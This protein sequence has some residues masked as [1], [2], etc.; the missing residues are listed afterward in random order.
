MQRSQAAVELIVILAVALV[1]LLSILAIN[2]S[3]MTSSQ[4]QIEET[5]ARTALGDIVNAAEL[6]YQGGVGSKTRVFVTLPDNIDSTSVSG[7]SVEISLYTAGGLNKIHRTTDFFV[8]GDIPAEEGNHWIDVEARQNDVLIGVETAAVCG[9]DAAEG[10]EIC[11]GTDLRGES[12]ISQG[13]AGGVL[14]C[15]GDCSAYDTSGCTSVTTCQ[16]ACS[17]LGFGSWQCRNS[18]SGGWANSAPE[19]DAYCS[20]QVCCCR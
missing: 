8:S 14:G 12:C 11:D 1:I 5:K 19:G 6:V 20:P 2:A 4:S 9:N 13:Y 3:T 18:C 15:L 16:N 17:A 7:Q 10:T